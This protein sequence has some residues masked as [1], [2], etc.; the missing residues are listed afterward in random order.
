MEW[1]P[2]GEGVVGVARN[3]EVTDLRVD[4][5]VDRFSVGHNSPADSRA[6]RDVDEIVE[7][8]A[9]LQCILRQFQC[10]LVIAGLLCHKAPTR[11][12][13]TLPGLIQRSIVKR[14]LIAS[15]RQIQTPQTMMQVT[16]FAL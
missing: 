9:C 3:S 7:T 5:S 12:N 6:N 13:P 10:L 8:G 14:R 15:L 16:E 2:P 11:Q 4:K 1:A